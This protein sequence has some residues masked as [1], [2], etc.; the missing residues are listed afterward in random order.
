[1]DKKQYQKTHPWITFKLNLQK[2]SHTFWMLLGEAQSKC[3]HIAGVPLRPEKAEELHRIYLTKGIRATTAIEGNTLSEEEVRKII[4]SDLPVPPSKEYLKQEILNIQDACNSI[5]AR[6]A[7]PSSRGGGITPD[8]ILGYNALVLKKLPQKSEVL[9]GN[10]RTFPVVAGSYRGAPAED[11]RYLLERFCHWM[12]D[13][14]SFDLGKSDTLSSGILKAILAHIYLV[15]IHPFA[16]GNGRTARLLEFRFLLE[17]GAPS[18]AG[19]LLSNHYNETRDEYYRH[20]EIS[21]RKE[22][23]IL[24]FLEYALQGFVDQLDEQ[25]IHIRHDQIEVTW[26]NF[27]HSQ[28]GETQT[29]NRRKKLLL[30][31]SKEEGPVPR[32]RILTIDTDVAELYRKKT[33]KT[34]SRDLSELERRQL[35]KIDKKGLSPRR[36]RIIAFMP[37]LRTDILSDLLIP[38]HHNDKGK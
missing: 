4:D 28:F 20:L 1:M 10:I 12:N 8:E 6:I 9:P 17:A 23:G 35:L 37:V 15:W 31:L 14:S 34:L 26:E 21:W 38:R 36:D 13:P 33:P 32:N 18:P 7:D 2:A 11:C 30:A 22:N 24:D 25:I 16:D 5:A 27:L 3:R 19:H 29:E